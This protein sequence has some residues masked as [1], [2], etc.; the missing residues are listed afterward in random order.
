[1]NAKIIK[2][3]VIAAAILGLCLVATQSSLWI[4]NTPAEDLSSYNKFDAGNKLSVSGTS[5]TVTESTRPDVH[6]LTL[7]TG[8]DF[9][10]NIDDFILHFKLRLTQC[11]P[12][13]LS[14][15]F[16]FSNDAQPDDWYYAGFGHVFYIYHYTE[17][18]AE[19][20]IR[21]IYRDLQYQG[22]SSP[23]ERI[24]DYSPAADAAMNTD[25][26]FTLVR[27]GTAM[28]LHAYSDPERMQTLRTDIMTTTTAITYRY[29]HVAAGFNHAS[30]DATKDAAKLSSV[31]SDI[32][33]QEYTGY[34][35]PVAEFTWSPSAPMANSVVTF[36]ASSS[37]VFTAGDAY[38]KW[39][40]DGDGTVDKTEFNTLVTT[41]NYANAGTYTAELEIDDGQVTHSTSHV[42]TVTDYVP[43][44]HELTVSVLDGSGNAVDGASVSVVSSGTDM[45]DTTVNGQCTFDLVDGTYTVQAEKDGIGTG[46][47]T[48]TMDNDAES[49]MVVL[50]PSAVGIPGFELLALIA[51]IGISY[52]IV[53]RRL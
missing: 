49:V 40:F 15:G 10:E 18:G 46:I 5:V 24:I 30:G 53:R 12:Y 8:S 3:V 42:I 36:D 28:E 25:I 17:D 41:W 11:E 6:Y 52:I 38:F 19:G 48:V 20:A 26:Y 13:S 32:H 22:G 44:T 37:T 50:E 7:D 47:T 27:R 4:I 35:E 2:I 45:S 9:S 29:M 14:G 34:A 31:I 33:L 1:M 21:F 39:D 43:T 16:V 51:A 23:N